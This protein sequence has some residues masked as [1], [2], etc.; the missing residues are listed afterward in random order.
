MIRQAPAIKHVVQAAVFGRKVR[1][2]AVLPS[3]GPQLLDRLRFQDIAF[4]RNET[5]Q[6]QRN[7]NHNGLTR[8]SSNRE[9][10]PSSVQLMSFRINGQGAYRETI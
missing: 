9:V 4:P 5:P 7:Q 6:P 8:M 2:V 3:H 10:D 1:D